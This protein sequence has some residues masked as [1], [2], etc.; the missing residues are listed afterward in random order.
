MTLPAPLRRR[1]A[2]LPALLLALLL[3]ACGKVEMFSTLQEREANEI[4]AVLMRAGIVAEKVPGKQGNVAVRV[5]S[6]RLPEAVEVLN[7][8]GLPRERFA[9]MGELFRREGLISSPAEERVRYIFGVTQELS[10][11]LNGI[12]GVLSARV[13]VVMPNNDPLA[14]SRPS[15]AAVMIRHL[16]GS[17][18]EGAVP[19]VKE[20]VVNAIEGLT[21]DRVSVVLVRAA[22]EAEQMPLVAPPP[23]PLLPGPVVL[24]AAAVFGLSLLGNGLLVLLLLRRRT[25]RA[26]RA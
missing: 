15:S 24:A 10:R 20:L 16:P 12:D 14:G 6:D 8:A 26:V 25:G 13:H 11:T 1:L 9:T 19:Q 17:Q 4:L 22:E 5:P 7:R 18:V 23:Q 21:Y 3:A 2:L